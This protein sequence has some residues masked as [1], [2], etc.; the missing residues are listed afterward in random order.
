MGPRAALAVENAVLHARLRRPPSPSSAPG[1]LPVLFFGDLFAARAATVAL[2]P[3]YQEYLDP[4]GNELDG[5]RRRFETLGSLRAADRQSLTD[6]Q[7]ERAIATMRG[8]FAP[9]RPV[10]SRWFRP[11]TEVL[12]GLGLRYDLGQ[13]AHLDLV[14]EA[15]R[16][17]WSGLAPDELRALRAAD[18]PFLRWQLATFPLDLVICNGRT[19]FETVRRMTA[20]HIVTSG[21]IALVTWFVALAEMPGRTMGVV[22]WNRSLQHPTGLGKQGHL[23]LGRVLVQHLAHPLDAG[24]DSG[25]G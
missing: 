7:C 25:H 15:T 4:A 11:I 6:E 20:A 17:T 21:R 12:T 2:N 9:G 19:A 14:Q 16:P 1:S 24:R 23:E 10:Y 18:E 22:G 8:Y 13:A 3:S 5:V